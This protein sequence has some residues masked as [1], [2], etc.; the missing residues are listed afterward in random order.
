MLPSLARLTPTAGGASGGASGGADEDEWS[1]EL[2]RQAIQQFAHEALILKQEAD[3]LFRVWS[4]AHDRERAAWVALHFARQGGRDPFLLEALE[5]EHA[6]LEAAAYA[7]A[8][9]YQVARRRQYALDNR[10]DA[11]RR[12][13][14]YRE[15]DL[16][17]NM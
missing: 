3:R 10:V 16:V 7:H 4:E 2:L 17:D 15:H 13:M 6:K 1:D 5:A 11:L 8:R 12:K 9:A 14:R